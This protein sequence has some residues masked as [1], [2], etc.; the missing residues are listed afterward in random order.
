[1]K[2]SGIPQ[3]LAGLNLKE[4][5]SKME[6]PKRDCMS[7]EGHIA[8]AVDRLVEHGVKLVMTC[9]SQLLRR[10]MA[11]YEANSVGQEYFDVRDEATQEKYRMVWK[12]ICMYLLLSH[13]DAQV[14]VCLSSAQMDLVENILTWAE[15]PNRDDFDEISE[16]LHKILRRA[17]GYRL[18]SGYLHSEVYTGCA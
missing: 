12:R 18:S 16:D 3:H 17:E 7:P 11:S 9:H 8:R 5:R 14:Q 10:W 4:L 6:V 2:A 1:M 15:G 13:A